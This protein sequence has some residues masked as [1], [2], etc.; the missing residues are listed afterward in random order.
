M[1]IIKEGYPPSEIKYKVLEILKDNP[2][3]AYSARELSELIKCD[4]LSSVVCCLRRLEKAGFTWSRRVRAMNTS[5]KRGSCRYYILDKKK[6]ENF[7]SDC[8]EVL[9]DK[10]AES[11]RSPASAG[12][13]DKK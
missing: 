4:K 11:Q 2:D 12:E 10:E 1:E 8:I 13:P 7:I 3:T 6:M 5:I 9:E